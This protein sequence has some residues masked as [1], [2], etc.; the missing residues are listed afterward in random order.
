M[1]V[2]VK[3]RIVFNPDADHEYNL[4]CKQLGIDE[5]GSG[6]IEEDIEL[7]RGKI[8]AAISKEFHV[9]PAA[10]QIESYTLNL[11]FSIQGP[12]NYTLDKFPGK[13]Q[14]EQKGDDQ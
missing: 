5:P 11:N 10:V 9:E 3:A 13:K 4:D 7:I 6:T 2:D 8:S 12:V 1:P 14:K